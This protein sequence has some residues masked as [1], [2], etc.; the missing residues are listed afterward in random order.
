[1]SPD[2]KNT[3]TVVETANSIAPDLVAPEI[4]GHH[5]SEVRLGRRY[6]FFE[7]PEGR[8]A[9]VRAVGEGAFRR[10]PSDRN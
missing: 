2:A 5:K 9:F 7:S 3:V 1:M 8:S 6:W 4:Y 10:A